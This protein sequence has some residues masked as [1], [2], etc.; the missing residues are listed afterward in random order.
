LTDTAA[1][2]DAELTAYSTSTYVLDKNALLS[3]FQ[4]DFCSQNPGLAVW[5]KV[6]CAFE[7]G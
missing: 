7:M 4:I 5:E 3:S 2:I 6:L 1:Y